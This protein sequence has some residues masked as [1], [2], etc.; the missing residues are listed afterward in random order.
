MAKHGNEISVI[1]TT[2]HLGRCKGLFHYKL[3]MLLSYETSLVMT[4]TQH[5]RSLEK[6]PVYN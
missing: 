3:D 1:L 4:G 6:F 5:K 2:L